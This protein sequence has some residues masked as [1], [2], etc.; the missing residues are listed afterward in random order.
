MLQCREPFRK[1]R[2]PWTRL[3]IYVDGCLQHLIS[4]L[5]AFKQSSSG[6]AVLIGFLH[7]L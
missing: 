3:G 1:L 6:G 4:S 2:I 5:Q 7:R